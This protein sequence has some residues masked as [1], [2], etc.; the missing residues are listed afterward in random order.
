MDSLADF[1]FNMGHHG[2]KGRIYELL[3]NE[4]CNAGISTELKK[5]MLLLL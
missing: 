2:L 1:T 5:L 4:V 3:E